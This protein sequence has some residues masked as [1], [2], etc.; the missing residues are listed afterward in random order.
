MFASTAPVF[1]HLMVLGTLNILGMI[2]VH[3]AT[4]AVFL[5]SYPLNVVTFCLD[6]LSLLLNH[7]KQRKMWR[8][9]PL[10]VVIGWTFLSTFNKQAA[11]VGINLQ[12]EGLVPFP[13]QGVL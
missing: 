11:L 8:I 12:G 1:D 3:S 13:C 5:F 7:S 4:S 10:T 9:G 6:Q 2:N